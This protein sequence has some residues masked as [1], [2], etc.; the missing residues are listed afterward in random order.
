MLRSLVQSVVGC[1]THRT[2]CTSPTIV[3]VMDKFLDRVNQ[4]PRQVWIEGMETVDVHRKGIMEL[5]PSVFATTPRIDVIH[6]NVLWQKNY[7]WVRFDEARNRAEMPGGGRKPWPQKGNAKAHSFRRLQQ[8]ILLHMTLTVHH[9]PFHA[10]A[11]KTPHR[12]GQGS[13]R[14]RSIAAIFE[15]RSKPWAAIADHTLLHAAFLYA[16][17]GSDGYAIGQIGPR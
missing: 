11:S 5:H 16:R 17:H 8:S 3:P 1:A 4:L 13:A 12:R 10:N 7:K 9:F 14:F 2:F 15:G 6:Q